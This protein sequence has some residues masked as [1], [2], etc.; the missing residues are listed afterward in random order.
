M[1]FN[2]NSKIVK[3]VR[4]VTN[5][6]PLETLYKP[7]RHFQVMKMEATFVLVQILV[8][9]LKSSVTSGKSFNLSETGFIGK[10]EIIHSNQHGFENQL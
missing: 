8:L 9:S 6:R 7:Q 2:F 5:F 10:M 3:G 1:Y 4:L